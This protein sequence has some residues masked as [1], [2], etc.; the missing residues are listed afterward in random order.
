MAVV[1]FLLSQALLN[2]GLGVFS[3]LYNLYLADQGL[4]LPFIGSFNAM[5]VLAVGLSAVP[6]G[7]VARRV[8]HRA[9]LTVGALCLVALQ[10]LLL[11]TAQPALLLVVS[12]GWGIA[13]ALCL[14][15]MGPFIAEQVDAAGRPAAFGLL[16]AVLSL[17][18]VLGSVLGGLLPGLL[19]ALLALP[20]P[21]GVAAYRA[22]LGSADLLTLLGVVPLLLLPRSTATHAIQGQESP[23][24]RSQAWA[25]RT[26]RRTA[27][28][29]CGT[30]ALYSL[31]SGLV[32]PFFNVYF[33]EVQHLPTT[34]IGL[35][36]ALGALLS[37]P[38]SLLAPLL[39]ARMGAVGALVVCRL[40][41][42]P[43]LLALA[44][45]GSVLAIV[46]AGFLG[47]Y[48]LINV[49]GAVDYSFSMDA[50]PAR[51]RSL[52]AGLRSGTFNTCWAAGA[53]AAGL[54]LGHTGY[55]L[56]FLAS[57]AL[58]ALSGVA[59]LLLFREPLPAPWWARLLPGRPARPVPKG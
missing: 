51:A 36:F 50:V 29:I 37:T 25:L 31:A 19:A 38:G 43:C 7:M 55:A 3:V 22:A 58:T 56:M 11:F 10:A 30:I 2:V 49:S 15:P 33:A 28:A 23:G 41:I 45:G 54:I 5:N 17:A 32:A 59:F 20:S 16:F 14:V 47:R 27:V 26:V 46:A 42:V 4:A 6:I 53:W 35:L 13:Q 8:S 24:P 40:A 1:L 9:V 21:H 44:G 34:M 48:L 39:S 12:A 52:V 18:T 57:A